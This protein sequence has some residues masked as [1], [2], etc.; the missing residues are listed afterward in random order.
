LTRRPDELVVL[1]WRGGWGE[2]LREEVSDPFTVLTGMPV[3][4]EPHVGLDLPDGL[5]ARVRAGARPPVDVVW[6]NA[7]PAL[8]AAAEDL[9]DPLTPDEVPNLAALHPR[10]QPARSRGWPVVMAYVVL[11]VLVW[12]RD[13]FPAGA[14]TSWRALLD[15]RHRGRIALYPD[16][17]GIHPVAQV[18]GGGQLADIPSDMRACWTTLRA[19]RPQ[20]AELDYSVGMEERLVRGKLDLC[21]RALPNALAFQRAGADVGWVAPEEGVPDTADAL[22]VPRGLAHETARWAKRY[23]DFA[24]SPEV[25][26]RWCDALGVLGVRRDADPPP[27]LRG[28]PHVPASLDDPQ[29]V[30]HVPDVVKLEHEREWRARFREI[31]A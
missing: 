1:S 31:F 6:S 29:C 24:L 26:Q 10:A 19:L 28:V 25:H 27:A 13:A 17:N 21:F 22:W 8:H 11:Y 5:L 23:I 9:C 7:V 3:R 30:L 16:G 20:A 15:P 18:L 12:R 4:H 2:A 14:P